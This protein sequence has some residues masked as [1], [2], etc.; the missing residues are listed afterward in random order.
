MLKSIVGAIG[1]GEMAPAVEDD[2]TAGKIGVGAPPV[3][4]KRSQGRMVLSKPPE[5]SMGRTECHVAG[6]PQS[7]CRILE[8]SIPAMHWRA[9]AFMC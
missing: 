3:E 5:T 6:R 8:W 9:G 4:A 7:K 1:N 2:G